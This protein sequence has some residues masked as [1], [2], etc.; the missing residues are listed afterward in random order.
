M[1]ST[2]PLLTSDWYPSDALHAGAYSS[3][4]GTRFD[5]NTKAV[6]T[7]NYALINGVANYKFDKTISGYLKLENLLDREYQSVDGYATAGRSFYLG[8]KAA[9]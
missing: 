5:T 1:R 4:I 7:G 2:P 3:F 8:V 9:F 6:Q